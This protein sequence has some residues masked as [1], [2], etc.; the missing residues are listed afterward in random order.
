MK[1]Q[2]VEKIPYDI[3]GL[4]A[5]RLVLPNCNLLLPKAKDGRPWKRDSST[6]WSDYEKV[7]FKNCGG[8]WKCPNIRCPFPKEYG[9]KIDLN[10]TKKNAV[11]SVERWE[12]LL[13][14]K[15]KNT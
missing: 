9:Y 1:L 14:V 13:F 12:S 10:L 4:S 15:Q 5:Y 11:L 6:K 8:S 2:D 7:Q 3:V